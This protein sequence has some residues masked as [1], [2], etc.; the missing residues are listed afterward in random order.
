[1][2]KI[3][4]LI[5]AFILLLA[6]CLIVDESDIFPARAEAVDIV[7]GY[8]GENV[9]W[10]L[11]D[12][13]L[14]L[15]GS[16]TMATYSKTNHP[17]YSNYAYA[18]EE[19]HIG[20]EIE[21]LSSYAFMSVGAV[22]YS[23]LRKVVISSVKL[24]AIPAYCFFDDFSLMEVVISSQIKSIAGGAFGCTKVHGTQCDEKQTRL[25]INIPGSVVSGS[26]AFDGRMLGQISFADTFT[27]IPP[28]FFAYSNIDTLDIST[29]I[30]SIGKYAFKY[31]RI[32]NLSF[33]EDSL[34]VGE[35][36]FSYMA[37]GE[38]V[39]PANVSLSEY[40]FS[41][42]NADKVKFEEGV[43]KTG[44]GVLSNAKVGRIELP[45]TLQQ[46]S[47]AAFNYCSCNEE[48]VIPNSVTYIGESA[49][50]N[51]SNPALPINL[52]NGIQTIVSRAFD[53]YTGTLYIPKTVSKFQTISN[54]A[55]A[56]SDYTNEGL[57]FDGYNVDS[58]NEYYT[59]IDG[60]LFNKEQTRIIDYPY[61]KKD[62]YYKI[63]SSVTVI[64][65]A[66]NEMAGIAQNK[67]IETLIYPDDTL[68]QNL[69]LI[70]GSTD[71]GI[72]EN[73][74]L[75]NI[76]LPNKEL[77]AT[78]TFLWNLKGLEMVYYPKEITSQNAF[79]T[80][81]AKN[82]VMYCEPDSMAEKYAKENGKNYKL[83]Q[84]IT[85]KETYIFIPYEIEQGSGMI[86]LEF[87][88]NECVVD[89]Q[90]QFCP[91]D[92]SL[93]G[94]I[95]CARGNELILEYHASKLGVFDVVILIDGI[96]YD[97]SLCVEH[98][99]GLDIYLGENIE[100]VMDEYGVYIPKITGDVPYVK[101]L[102]YWIDELEMGGFFEP[103]LADYSYEDIINMPL[104]SLIRDIEG[105]AYL[106][107]VEDVTIKEL[108]A[109]AIF[110]EVNKSY[111]KQMENLCI[112]YESE[113]G[114]IPN[115]QT[116]TVDYEKAYYMLM[117][118]Y[119]AYL[120]MESELA[121]GNETLNKFLAIAGTGIKE[122][123]KEMLPIVIKD[124]TF[125]DFRKV[126]GYTQKLPEVAKLSTGMIEEAL[127]LENSS[128]S[129]QTTDL[130]KYFLVEDEN[131]LSYNVKNAVDDWKT[132]LF[133]PLKTTAKLAIKKAAN[134]VTGGSLSPV[135]IAF[136]VYECF[137][138]INTHNSPEYGGVMP[139]AGQ[140]V[141]LAA[142]T[143]QFL[144]GF[145]TPLLGQISFPLTVAKYY[146]DLSKAV[147]DQS[148]HVEAGWYLMTLYN[149]YNRPNC[150]N[151]Y[152]DINDLS[153]QHNL[154]AGSYDVSSELDSALRHAYEKKYFM[155]AINMAPSVAET[156]L[157]VKTA[158]LAREITDEVGRENA[159]AILMQILGQLEQDTSNENIDVRATC[160]DGSI[161]IEWD[162]YSDAEKYVLECKKVDSEEAGMIYSTDNLY[163]F[164]N[165]QP[166][167][168][169]QIY[170]I[171]I[172]SKDE[173]IADNTRGDCIFTT[174]PRGSRIGFATKDSQNVCIDQLVTI[175]VYDQQPSFN[176]ISKI[177][178]V[179]SSGEEQH[180]GPISLSGAEDEQAYFSIAPREGYWSFDETYTIIIRKGAFTFFDGSTNEE[181]IYSFKTN[182]SRCVDMPKDIDIE[183][184]PVNLQGIATD[185]IITLCVNERVQRP[186]TNSDIRVVDSDGN[187]VILPISILFDGKKFS[188][189][190]RPVGMKWESGKSYKIS[191]P[192]GS[193]CLMD[194]VVNRE[195]NITFTTS[196]ENSDGKVLSAK[197]NI[198]NSIIDVKFD[199]DELFGA[200]PATEY[201]HKLAIFSITLAT[202]MYDSEGLKKENGVF[203]TSYEG[204]KDSHI[205]NSLMNLGLND[206]KFVD[207]YTNNKKYAFE[208]RGKYSPFWLSHKKVVIGGSQKE[209][210]VVSIRGTQDCEWVDNFD[211]GIGEIHQGFLQAADYVTEELANYI[212]K[213]EVDKSNLV[214]LITGHSRGAATANLVG[215][216]ID[217]GEYGPLQF[218]NRDNTFVYTFATPNTSSAADATTRINTFPPEKY[219]NIH[220]IVNPEDFVTKVL[221][222][223]W[224][225]GRYG[226]T[227]VLPTRTAKY[228]SL[229]YSD[230]LSKVT[231]L[232]TTE[233]GKEYRPY[234]GGSAEVDAYVN[235]LTAKVSNVSEY[236]SKPID[237]LMFSSGATLNRLFVETLA[238]LCAGKPLEGG[239]CFVGAIA[240]TYGV[241]GEYTAG[242]FLTHEAIGKV[243][244][245][246]TYLTPFDLKQDFTTAHQAETYLAMMTVLDE[247][248]LYSDV[249][250]KD[251][252]YSKY[253][254]LIRVSCPVDVVVLDEGGNKVG[255]IRNN[256]VDEDD[257]S[258]IMNVEGDSKTFILLNDQNY[259][260][261]LVGFDTGTMDYSISEYDLDLGEIKRE[262]YTDVM[263]EK[264]IEYIHEI[265]ANTP[266][267][268]NE[269]ID[270][271]MNII[272]PL[273]VFNVDSF[274][275]IS[276]S[277]NVEGKGHAT[278]SISGLTPGEYITLSA[279][280]NDFQEFLGWYEGENLISTD[281]QIGLSITENKS[282]LAKF[283]NNVV[284]WQNGTKEYKKDSIAIDNIVATN[285]VDQKN[286]TKTGK[287]VWILSDD[288][289]VPS[290]DANH[291]LISKSSNNA[292]KVATINSKGI[293]S[294]KKAGHLYAYCIDTGSGNYQKTEVTV[295]CAPTKLIYK[296]N[297]SDEKK[298]TQIAVAVNQ[299]ES[300]YVI[301]YEK[302]GNV[303]SKCTYEVLLGKTEYNENLSAFLEAREDGY[304]KLHITGLKTNGNK[305][306]NAKIIVMNNE[307]GKKANLSVRVENPITEMS[308][309][310]VGGLSRKNDSVDIP[311]TINT[312]DGLMT[313]D[314]I[315]IIV[316]ATQP[317]IDSNGK[318][319][320]YT[321]SKEIKA[322]LAKEYSK[323]SLKCSKNIS[324]KAGVYAIVTNAVT[325]KV[326]VIHLF[327]VTT[328]MTI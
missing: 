54:A 59:S 239:I 106:Y 63:P 55:T 125:N 258:I 36:A 65:S 182:C 263:L 86:S 189:I 223:A 155:G 83:V 220:N 192:S 226:V 102:Q 78:N 89:K 224:E 303:S 255:A 254:K 214:V 2:K 71:F 172:N 14:T 105:N 287:L 157:Y 104:K 123:V 188:I 41:G 225:Y 135:S 81:N 276:V 320:N 154:D 166:N 6:L 245:P 235:L 52:P 244:I 53:N 31:A 288:Q 177:S 74:T 212:E 13:I 251:L 256:C 67:Y 8:V 234:A 323:I 97:I 171:A 231:K 37:T 315:K 5:Y 82:C 286:K 130:V 230:F 140:N 129:I 215:K 113:S 58:Q 249:F 146:T 213:T 201:N 158:R 145:G 61:G 109:M 324:E 313:T 181:V 110:K 269:L 264:D 316:S 11:E 23:K 194:N 99:P 50:R 9:T 128:D 34:S 278:Q 152:I 222:A 281:L 28:E 57:R 183:C 77:E 273:G 40:A 228:S 32:G 293:I 88:G 116:C 25:N 42:L 306:M 143:L 325:K 289:I 144:A 148:K 262:V 259:T 114:E 207:D 284:V 119:N 200:A 70:A 73:T 208:K 179:D 96:E 108:M 26:Q 272:E 79:S 4:L 92:D 121:S 17:E 185:Q 153:I 163:K 27:T 150:L 199:P 184:S 247:N 10:S 218:L 271:N 300:I 221:P 120:R 326:K 76:I 248:A 190:I 56:K 112:K 85:N 318:K 137:Y 252:I 296:R 327:D 268:A 314:K 39:I 131:S 196:N 45:S 149:F 260:V 12:G 191:I 307:S 178:I 72:F 209:L 7:G 205:Y 44:V 138:D 75:K 261:Q 219:M 243:K 84:E 299:E 18:I 308:A 43:V 266:I 277:V 168:Q 322:F 87:F 229:N 95:Y 291:N 290:L 204:I 275:G 101:E 253:Y 280:P 64:N 173:I 162:D 210:F 328:D 305:V 175:S 107:E 197:V 237:D 227:Y 193:I 240:G 236:Y 270:A 33:S 156:T 38:L 310:Y 46:I 241:L 47:K 294:A 147:Y 169:Y 202:M 319:V 195:Q 21:S 250:D 29:N 60:V 141:K 151:A 186:L 48:I 302:N 283:T 115:S 80:L 176:G 295:L 1:M 19:I 134:K 127:D 267:E 20:G 161:M 62:K 211:P 91:A 309:E 187:S 232:I 124:K 217:N 321:S 118:L 198:E 159:L 142:S 317:I 297:P 136:D 206:I 139:D 233:Y 274:G 98:T 126:Y 170:V 246:N 292:K 90:I 16:G 257:L 180:I 22:Q 312:A 160:Y 238:Y 216:I 3:H 304:L 301:P 132:Y 35:Y 203:D 285:W 242:F 164:D 103:Y 298:V 265:E 24:E 282:Y 51:F 174:L 66:G 30:K 133:N 279:A 68:L 94:T 100:L 167:T 93:C 165:L 69:D 111:I 122:I 15:S 311:L 117:G 49:F